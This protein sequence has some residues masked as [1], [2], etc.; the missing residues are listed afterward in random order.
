MKIIDSFEYYLKQID[1]NRGYEYFGQIVKVDLR[2]ITD[3]LEESL[4]TKFELSQNYPNPFNPTTIIEYAIPNVETRHAAFLHVSLKVY[5][6][7]EREVVTLVNKQQ[8]S[9]RYSV[10]FDAS[11]LTSG[12]Y[13]YLLKKWY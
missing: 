7:L 3:I 13:F 11:H 6:M 10:N 9:G 8:V 12:F 4:P 2:K 1:T 5:D